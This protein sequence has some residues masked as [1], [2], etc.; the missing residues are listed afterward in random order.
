MGHPSCIREL[1]YRENRGDELENN[2]IWVA[3]RSPIDRRRPQIAGARVRGHLSIARKRTGNRYAV[4][5]VTIA[6]FYREVTATWLPPFISPTW[7]SSLVRGEA[8]WYV[9]K[10][11]SMLI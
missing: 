5:S 11:S 8:L 1:L 9:A 4:P 6:T 10:L 2:A 3:S 7:R